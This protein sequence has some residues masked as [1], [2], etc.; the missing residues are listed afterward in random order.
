[1]FTKLLRRSLITALVVAIAISSAVG[2]QNRGTLRGL[3]KDE[4]GASIVG[5]SVTIT[6]AGAQTKTAVSNNEGIYLFSGLAP[7]KYTVRASAKGFAAS[8]DEE[9]ELKAGQR[10]TL[11]L[12]L[13]VTIEEQ[14]VTVAG[15]TPVSTDASAN[16]NQT[17]ISG[18][19]LDALP[20]DPE[21]LAAALQALAGPSVGPNG[22]QIFVD[23][24]S[25]GTLP[26]KSSIREIRINQNPFAAENDQ[27]SGRIDVFTK[28]GTDKLRGSGFFNFN[29][30]SLNS[31]NPFATSSK[32]R[33]PFQVRQYGGNLS[34]PLV[35]NKASYFVDFERREVNDN[36]LVTATILDPNLNRLTIG[37]GVLTP[38]RF[39]N[40]SP[41]VD[42]ALNRN[43][44]LVIRYSYNHSN[45]QNNGV[46]NFSLPERGFTALSTTHNIQLTETA[47][48][49]PTT[50]NETR[51]QFTRSRNENLGDSSK[52]TLVVSG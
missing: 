30:E 32:K 42:Y 28:P 43:N 25:G 24:F 8:G 9:V 15:E 27:P 50:I 45:L 35:A 26:S 6:D 3:V 31:R 18:K 22:G 11:D 49:N 17:V 2:Q 20:D 41:R 10:Q 14:K 34:G 36:E 5:A 52:P 37:A 48:I 16:A 33:T 51:F 19:D 7:G 1:M 40:L 46:G 39:M 29:D 13:K 44:T 38:R 12:T 23:G 4:L 47:V 21:E